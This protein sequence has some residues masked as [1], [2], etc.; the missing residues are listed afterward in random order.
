[1]LVVQLTAQLALF[2]AGLVP[3]CLSRLLTAGAPVA[4]SLAFHRQ[5]P[6]VESLTLR[7]GHLQANKPTLCRCLLSAQ[8]ILNMVKLFG[9]PLRVN[10]AAQ[11]RTA[12]EVGA[13]LFIGGLSPEVD[14][15]V[16]WLAGSLAGIH[17][18]LAALLNRTMAAS[19]AVM[20]PG[21]EAKRVACFVR[22]IC[23]RRLSC[24]S[25]PCTSALCSSLPLDCNK[26]RRF[27]ITTLAYIATL[28]SPL[29]LLYDTFSAFGVIVNNPKIMRDPDTGLPKG[30]G[31]LSFDS[32][33]ASGLCAVLC[34]G[35]CKPVGC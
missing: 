24:L 25:L 31:F 8:Q 17:Q 18:L 23:L 22:A 10:K 34:C 14:E 29:Q 21:V 12:V 3:L 28:P 13:N 19:V 33:E 32:F 35:A 30:F 1:M 16:R 27:L 20:V 7:L 26:P 2:P 5:L 9:K 15:K 4:L 11:D 6:A